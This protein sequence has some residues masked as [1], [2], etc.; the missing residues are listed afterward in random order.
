MVKKSGES[1]DIF[2]IWGDSYNVVSKMWEDSYVNLYKPWIESTG[3][4]L[5]KA[6]KLQSEATAESYNM[7]FGYFEIFTNLNCTITP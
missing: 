2:K 1:K 3:V 4:L 6:A 7:T 5:D